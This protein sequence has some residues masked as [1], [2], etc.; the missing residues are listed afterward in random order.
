MKQIAVIGRRSSIVTANLIGAMLRRTTG[1]K[2]G[3][4]NP[5]DR[6]DALRGG[7]Q[8]LALQGCDCAVAAVRDGN[9]EQSFQI[10]VLTDWGEGPVPN[11][12]EACEKLVVN[13]DDECG[14][15]LAASR[16]DVLTCSE[17]KDEADLTAKNLRCYPDRIEF[18]ALTWNS[19][20]R[21]RMPVLGGYDIYHGL[22]ALGCGLSM[23]YTLDRLAPSIEQAAGMPGHL[24]QIPTDQPFCLVVDQANHALELEGLLLTLLP[25]RGKG[26][27]LR[28]LPGAIPEEEWSLASDVAGGLADD[29]I[30]PGSDRGQNVHELLNRGRAGDVLV[31][32]GVHEPGSKEDERR[33]A[34]QWLQHRNRSVV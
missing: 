32:A 7:L 1:W 17:R 31:I 12:A 8:Q 29:V 23:G 24:E 9:A 28:L 30:R 25:L 2:V 34:A 19:I 16:Q 33:M 11:A 27:M 14:R 15:R 5:E 26:G 13:L 6:G 10:G 20:H 18:E 21:V 22:A 4:L 3:V